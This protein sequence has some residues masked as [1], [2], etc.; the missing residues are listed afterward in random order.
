MLECKAAELLGIIVTMHGIEAFYKALSLS[1]SMAVL[2]T[3]AITS[4]LACWSMIS[5][6]RI[7]QEVF[8]Q[9][10]INLDPLVKMLVRGM[11]SAHLKFFSLSSS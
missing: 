8:D 2:K 11:S 4:S 1:D 5:V 6:N 10:K 3:F 9:L 7:D